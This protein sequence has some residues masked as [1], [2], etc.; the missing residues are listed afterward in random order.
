MLCS[1]WTKTSIF[2]RHADSVLKSL[3]STYRK[4]KLTSSSQQLRLNC[5]DYIIQLLVCLVRYS[6]SGGAEI[7]WS[8][9]LSVYNLTL[10]PSTADATQETWKKMVLS[11]LWVAVRIIITRIYSHYMLVHNSYW[12]I[13]CC[14]DD[15][16]L[17]ET[18][19]LLKQ[20]PT[21][22]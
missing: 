22:N 21:W 19:F 14:V 15:S 10:L 9:T 3:A 2:N 18:L 17:G 13:R 1:Y 6:G 11:L 12:P 16:V 7:W 4:V 8:G 5:S 20:D